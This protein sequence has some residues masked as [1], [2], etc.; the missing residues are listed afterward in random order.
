MKKTMNR[1]DIAYPTEVSAE[2]EKEAVQMVETIM[3]QK[4]YKAPYQ[5]SVDYSQKGYILT[6]IQDNH[7]PQ[8]MLNTIAFDFANA[9][10]MKYRLATVVIHKSYVV[11][12]TLNIETDIKAA[13]TKVPKTLLINAEE[14]KLFSTRSYMDDIPDDVKEEV[15][16]MLDFDSDE[17]VIMAEKAARKASRKVAVAI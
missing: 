7:V 12:E 14:D 8:Y 1:Y 11:L 13:F 2:N 6:L 15:E 9:V 3:A 16:D 17:A 10:R 4:H 5:I